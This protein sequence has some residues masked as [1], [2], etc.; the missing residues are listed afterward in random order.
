MNPSDATVCTQPLLRSQEICIELISDGNVRRFD[1]GAPLETLAVSEVLQDNDPDYLDDT[2]PTPHFV[3]G[4]SE[5]DLNARVEVERRL[6]ASFQGEFHNAYCD[7]EEGILIL[8]G[9]VSS[10]YSKQL[11][12]EIARKVDGVNLIVNRL[13]VD[14]P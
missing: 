2:S 12:Q 13:Q 14:R 9:N 10:F 7:I 1:L 3:V 4:R 5:I 8:C 11:A 6:R